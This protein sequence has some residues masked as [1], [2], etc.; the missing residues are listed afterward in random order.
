MKKVLTAVI[1]I[2][3]IVSLAGCAKGPVGYWKVT[4]IVAGDV[5]MSE[6]DAGTLGLTMLGSVKLQKSGK[7]EVVLLGEESEGEWTQDDDGTIK[8][9]WGTNKEMSGKIMDAGN[10]KLQDTQGSVY[11]LEK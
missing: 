6:E 2:C 8:V 3:M 5:V 4:K 9:T 7:C 10:M 1:V 11:T